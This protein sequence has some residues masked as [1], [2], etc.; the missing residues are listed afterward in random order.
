MLKKV[1][2]L[3]VAEKRVGKKGEDKK[4]QSGLSTEVNSKGY[5]KDIP[6][7]KPQRTR[8]KN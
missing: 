6:E 1:E 2:T 4:E 3:P 5:D 8:Y 7:E